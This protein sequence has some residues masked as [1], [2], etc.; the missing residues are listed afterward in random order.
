MLFRDKHGK[1]INISR[2]DYNN[3]AHYYKT[4]INNFK[5]D[6]KQE[7]KICVENTK[8]YKDLKRFLI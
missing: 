6:K 2:L 7:E 3:D 5:E 4:I 8:Q 1:L